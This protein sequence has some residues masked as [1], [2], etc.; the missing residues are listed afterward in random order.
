MRNNFWKNTQIF[1]SKIKPNFTGLIT[2]IGVFFLGVAARRPASRRRTPSLP[3][4]FRPARAIMVT[5]A[6]VVHAPAEQDE[7]ANSGAGVGVGAGEV[8]AS[9]DT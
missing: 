7:V 6:E 1:F 4:R 8:A 3:T 9:A 2:A 5:G